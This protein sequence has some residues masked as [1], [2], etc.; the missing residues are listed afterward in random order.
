[1][2]ELIQIGELLDQLINEADELI[3]KLKINSHNP[4]A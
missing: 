2:K 1:M 4:Q 3:K